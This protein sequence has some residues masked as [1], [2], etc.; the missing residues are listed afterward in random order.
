MSKYLN[1]LLLP[2][3]IS[4]TFHKKTDP[5]YYDMSKLENIELSNSEQTK[6]NKIRDNMLM[7]TALS[8]GA[9]NGLLYRT[10]QLEK[11]IEQHSSTLNRIFAF[12][13]LMLSGNVLPPVIVETKSKLDLHGSDVFHY[14]SKTFEII[15]Q[16]KFVTAPPTWHQYLHLEHKKVEDLNPSLLPQNRLE[17]KLWL[18]YIRKGWL[19]G[20]KQA[21]DIIINNLH[22]LSRDFNG[23]LMY[24]SLLKQNIVSPPYVATRDLGITGGGNNLNVDEKLLRITSLPTLNND[25]NSWKMIITPNE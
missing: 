25:P 3:L 1:Y 18:K 20:I 22:K 6:K 19:E 7:E 12:N 21:D 16:A 10:K 4:C 8:V 11:L 5:D 13:R 15:Q 23:M 24:Q 17:K 9:Q 14:A 2:L